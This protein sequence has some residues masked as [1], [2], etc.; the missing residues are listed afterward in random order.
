MHYEQIINFWFNEI[1]PKQWY[2][3]DPEFDL[4]IK[5]RFSQ[6]HEQAS[7]CEL[8]NWRQWPLGRLAEVIVLDQLSRNLY[9]D[10]YRAFA[11]DALAL[12]LAQEAISAN[13]QDSFTNTSQKSF[14]YMPFM[15]SES[16]AIHETAVQLFSEPGLESNLEFELKHKAIIDRFGRYPHRNI[17]LGRESTEEEEA[18]LK[19]PGSSF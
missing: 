18:F 3:K 8:A 7:R 16:K 5:D 17:I 9:R 2:V 13:V 1:K 15:H 19:Q 11:C 6:C 14:L 4:L 12:A 10:D